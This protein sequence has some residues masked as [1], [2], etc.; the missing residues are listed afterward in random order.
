MPGH[1]SKG[2]AQES[3]NAPMPLKRLVSPALMLGFYACLT[4]GLIGATYY[5]TAKRIADNQRQAQLSTL[6]QLAPKDSFDNDLLL[7]YF[8]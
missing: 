2:I 6:Y 3:T 7:D 8:W 1:E 4:A 5:L